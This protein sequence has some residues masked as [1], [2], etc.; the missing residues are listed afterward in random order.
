VGV[1]CSNK[2]IFLKTATL[3][4][5]GSSL[6]FFQKNGFPFLF[7]T[8]VKNTFNKTSKMLEMLNFIFTFVST[9][10]NRHDSIKKCSFKPKMAYGKKYQKNERPF[11]VLQAT[12]RLIYRCECDTAYQSM[13]L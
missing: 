7:D 5:S 6:A 4:S 9:K 13:G 10:N 3:R 8:K 12:T 11:E 1:V 2:F